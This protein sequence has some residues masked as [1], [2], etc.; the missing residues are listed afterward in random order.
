MSASTSTQANNVSAAAGYNM[1][2]E[3]GF[4]ENLVLDEYG[5]PMVLSTAIRSSSSVEA[6]NPNREI[7]TGRSW[8]NMM[9]DEY[10]EPSVL[11][12]IPPF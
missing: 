12:L 4:W 5:E 8:E 3:Q 9:L 6:A 2:M 11:M 1:G 10:G 7:K